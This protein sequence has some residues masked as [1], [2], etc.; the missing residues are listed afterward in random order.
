MKS[1][2]END[3][4]LS[5]RV[6]QSCTS[7]I[8]FE[9]IALN[10]EGK[11]EIINS[12]KEKIIYSIPHEMCTPLQIILGFG[13]IIKEVESNQLSN[14]EIS[15]I[16][17]SI[18][19][20]ARQLYQLIEKYLM[21]IDVES[22]GDDFS[23]KEVRMTPEYFRKTLNNIAE[24]YCRNN[25]LIMEVD[26]LCPQI[27]EDW[28]NFAIRE[29]VDNAF[30][31]SAAGEKVIVTTKQ[32]PEWCEIVIYDEG[33]GFSPGTID[34]IG[35]FEQF[36]RKK[37]EQQGVGLGLFLAKTIFEKHNGKLKIDSVLKKGSTINVV[38]QK[39]NSS[40]KT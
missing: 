40:T 14:E 38:L 2:I 4:R 34:K 15:E 36:E 17:D 13:E 12:L 1:Q 5:R 18:L 26:T 6:L 21:Y 28:V 8:M 32:L 20:S 25:D 22:N 39:N 30:K 33:R 23:K 37:I 9:D 10:R 7:S 31:F 19:I 11:V 27:K 3:D 35:A 16:G 29:L 24:K